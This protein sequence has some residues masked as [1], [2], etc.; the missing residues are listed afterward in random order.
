LAGAAYGVSR[1]RVKAEPRALGVLDDPAWFLDR[2]DFQ[3]DIAVL[4]RTDRKA[5]SDAVF[6]DERRPPSAGEQHWLP[7]SDLRAFQ[8]SNAPPA[9][10]WHT[11]FCCS[12]LI[13]SCLDAPGICL[14]LK[15]PL[16]LVHLSGA[17]RRGLPAADDRLSAA[18]LSHL[19]REFRPGERVVIKPSNGANA[20]LG[21]ADAAG[22]TLLLYSTCRDFV[23]SVIGGG[24]SQ[25]GG[26]G[27]R[28]TARSLLAE[29]MTMGRPS[30]RWRAEELCQMTDL[31]VA[32]LL[33]HVQ[34]G[35]FR[36]VARA[37]GAARVRSLNCD[38]FLASPAQALGLGSKRTTAIAAGPKMTHYAKQ[39]TTRFEA[40]DRRR[41]FDAI[42][43]ELG[44]TLDALV[45][46][47]YR[48]CPETP[49]GDPVGSPLMGPMS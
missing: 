10:I 31:Q 25:G 24:P 17:R 32:A 20:L 36:A 1:P 2:L 14:S 44:P 21:G 8:A 16:A 28:F 43:A 13:A 45:E 48:F 35:E 11:A 19:G 23:L 5:L 40:S 29:R 30:L 33:W 4:T 34:V 3:R 12:T 42:E 49:P 6:L 37:L 46:W 9:M 22:P 39:S 15:E 7:L 47:S 18:V 26:E 38:H 41:Q 27:R